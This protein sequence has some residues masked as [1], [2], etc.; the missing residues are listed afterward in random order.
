MPGRPGADAQAPRARRSQALV[1]HSS[2]VIRRFALRFA[3]AVSTTIV[4]LALLVLAVGVL[5]LNTEWRLPPANELGSPSSLFDRDGTPWYR[6]AAEVEHREVP[7]EAVSPYLRD[8]VVAT[9]DHRFY[10]HSGVDPLGVI[11]AVWENV[12][13]SE[14]RQGASTITQQYVKNTFVGSEVTLRRKV[15]EAVLAIQLEKDLSKDDILE[16]YL[17]RAYFGEGAYGA[18]AAAVTYF[19]TTAAELT[20]AQAATIASTLGR[21]ADFSPIDDPDGTLVR[22]DR[23]LQ[24]MATYGFVS[25]SEA[26]A[27]RAE[28]LGLAPFATPAPA[29][30]YLV[31]EIRRQ[32]L[33]TYGPDL[34]YRGGLTIT[35]TVELDRQF[36]LERA[37]IPNLPEQ[38]GFEPA[39]AA[40]DPNTG[41]V[42]AA[43]SGRGFE[44]SQ[45]DLALNPD[46]GRPSG[47]TFKVFALAAALEQGYTL[48]SS[49]AA[50]GQITIGDWSPRGG[51]CGGRCTLRQATAS[52]VNTVFAQVA[53]AVGSGPMTT[54]AERLGVRS[55][56]R[57]DDLTQVLGTSSVTALD[58]ASS[59]GTLAND[60][61]ACPARIIL[62]VTDADGEPVDP[63]DPRQ[64]DPD[65]V[66]RWDRRMRAEG[67]NLPDDG[68]GLGRCHRAVAPGVARN[69][70]IA[71]QD[72]VDGGTGRRAD[73]GV[74]QAGKT[75]TTQDSAQVWFVGYTPDLALSVMVSHIDGDIPLRNLPGCSSACFGGQLP[76]RIWADLAPALLEGVTPREFT[77]PGD[78]D[79]REGPAPRPPRSPVVPAARPAPAP[80]PPAAPAAPTAAPAIPEPTAAP[81]PP[82]PPPPPED[83]PPGP[84]GGIIGDILNPDRD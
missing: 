24:E 21:P 47:S 81:P 22:R 59:F 7:L 25:Q 41:D 37:M 65:D 29:A 73:I 43:W 63:P 28:P 76:A 39:A 11:R 50:P 23:V 68:P 62:S 55:T 1:I 52:S 78:A 8:A 33:A 83:D 4:I 61:V 27:A 53:N 46:Y 15:R 34:L 20:L 5:A 17:N 66:R 10:E 30:P 35:S 48:D 49:W 72:V 80:A 67:W 6:F 19:T 26:D 77:A 3:I 64:P 2:T 38:V 13:A 84:D 51:G 71:L 60:G 56:L 36:A 32:L 70:T 57:E 44:F 58:M 69:A 18:E 75:G 40:V 82:P 14:I 45:V 12:T 54:M 42:I 16:A 31:E 9:E 74:P 79:V